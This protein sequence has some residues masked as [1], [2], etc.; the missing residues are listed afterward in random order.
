MIRIQGADP[1]D[2]QTGHFTQLIWGDTQKVGCGAQQ[3]YDPETHGNTWL[4]VCNYNPAGNYL[5]RPIY[6]ISDAKKKTR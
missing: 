2:L 4:L 6:K 1:K 3:Y 5:K